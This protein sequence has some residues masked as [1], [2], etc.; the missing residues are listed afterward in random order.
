M[1]DDYCGGDTGY[2]NDD[3]YTCND[4]S[5][6]DVVYSSNVIID[7]GPVIATDNFYIG[8]CPTIYDGYDGG[9]QPSPIYNVGFETISIGGGVQPCYGADFHTISVGTV[10]PCYVAPQ[11][12]PDYT[13]PKAAY[14][15]VCVVL[16]GMLLI[17]VV[18]GKFQLHV[19]CLLF[20]LLTNHYCSCSYVFF[21]L[22]ILF[23]FYSSFI[24]KCV[25]FNSIEPVYQCLT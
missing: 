19:T 8:G 24:Y 1:S 22:I 15:F 12:Y 10:E 5:N 20:L 7:D 11:V 21:L 25:P 18:M 16:S 17:F 2:S 6:Q 23:Q 3:N 4:T 13:V 14:I 9:F